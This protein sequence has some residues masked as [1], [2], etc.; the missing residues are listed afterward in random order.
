MISF[1]LPIAPESMQSQTRFARRK[2][3]V[4][5]YSTD[6]KVTYLHD[7]AG[8]AA[9]YLPPQKM[10][11]PVILCLIFVL[12]RP[13]YLEG[14][15]HPAGWIPCAKR[16]DTTNLLKAFED[17]LSLAG[18]WNDDGQVFDSR[19]LKVYAERGGDAR[20]I[21]SIQEVPADYQP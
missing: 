5:T 20:T 9:A 12:A 3:R 21:V 8:Q 6:R 7:I 14:K 1:T 18:F 2:R 17:G 4:I 10:A 13:K 15:R 11:G 16:P 19:Q